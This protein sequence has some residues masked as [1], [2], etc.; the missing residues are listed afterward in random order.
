MTDVDPIVGDDAQSDPARDAGQPYAAT[1]V[2]TV[3]TL[4]EAD[5]GSRA[6]RSPPRR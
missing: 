6:I 2:Q 5:T 1:A 3:A 4:E